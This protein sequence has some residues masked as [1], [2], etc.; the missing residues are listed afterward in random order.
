MLPNLRLNIAASFEE[1]FGYGHFACNLVR[2]LIEQGVDVQL[3]IMFGHNVP[4]DLR[5]YVNPKPPRHHDVAIAS[6]SNN[7]TDVSATI[8]FTMS[9]VMDIPWEYGAQLKRYRHLIVPTEYSR[10]A[11]LKWHKRVH[12]CPLGTDMKW[13]PTP[14]KP[15]TFTAVAADHACPARKR[16]Q[17]LADTF[18]KTFPTEADVRLQLKRAPE[19]VKINTFDSR[20]HIVTARVSRATYLDMMQETTVGVQPSAMEGWSL[21]TNEF[22]AMGRPIITAPV[23]AVGDIWPLGALF[24]VDHKITKAPLAVF[25]GKGRIP[26]A[27]M[28]GIGRQMR[29]AY[30]NP[31]EVVRRGLVAYETAQNYTKHA[32]GQRF[33][34]LCQTLIHS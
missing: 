32:M 2:H 20:I 9:E 27:D 15:F 6:I 23:G 8:L 30:E 24:P 7:P 12:L 31:Q 25:L 28:K 11:A 3:S 14:F 26:Y 21:P 13:S 1:S 33:L 18:T 4:A 19:C 10:A 16:I 29:F 22:A 17:E 34:K 5:P